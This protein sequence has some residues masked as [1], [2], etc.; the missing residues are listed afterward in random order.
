MMTYTEAIIK[1]LVRLSIPRNVGWRMAVTMIPS[2]STKRI[3]LWVANSRTSFRWIPDLSGAG[4]DMDYLL[5][6]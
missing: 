6:T 1:M 2:R 3:A 4:D 5:F